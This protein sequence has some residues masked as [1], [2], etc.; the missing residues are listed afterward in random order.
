MTSVL[1]PTG[2]AKPGL[3]LRDMLLGAGAGFPATALSVQAS[4]PMFLAKTV[5]R[6]AVYQPWWTFDISAT[7][8]IF[9]FL[10]PQTQGS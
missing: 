5:N 10:Q 6:G 9:F 4:S 1:A 3:Q 8:V 7:K 2:D